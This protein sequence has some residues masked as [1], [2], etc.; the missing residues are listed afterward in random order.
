MPLVQSGQAHG[1]ALPP[2]GHTAGEQFFAAGVEGP[3]PGQR[4]AQ[5]VNDGGADPCADEDLGAVQRI[6]QAQQRSQ[7]GCALTAALGPAACQHG[8]DAQCG[9]SAV[10]AAQIAGDIY[11]AVQGDGGAAAGVQQS[12]HGGQIKIPRRCQGTYDKAVCPGGAQRRDLAAEQVDLLLRVEKI[13]RARPHQ[14]AHR[15]ADLRLDLAQQIGI[16]R[17]TAHSQRAAKLQSVCPALPG[18]AGGGETVHADFQQFHA[19]HILGSF[20]SL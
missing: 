15:Q 16:G 1:N 3:C 11:T 7:L 18:S 10:G 17:Q 5:L 4:S 8:V 13:P 20:S 9:G 6:P 19:G 14:A 2:E 12:A